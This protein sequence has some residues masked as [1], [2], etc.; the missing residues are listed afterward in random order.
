MSKMARNIGSI[1]FGPQ[2]SGTLP[3]TGKR[4][5]FDTGSVRDDRTGKGRYDLL[6]PVAMKRDAIL[7]EKGAIKYNDRNWEKGQPI[8]SYLDSAKRHMEC[9]TLD[10]LM[11]RESEEDH[12]AAVRWN[13]A[14][15]MHMEFMIENGLLP[16]DLDDRP[17]PQTKIPGRKYNN[18]SKIE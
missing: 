9:Y 12:L 5:E 7:M 8:M 16:I 6:S 3:D 15:M 13:I 11:G 10:L 17:K 18:E 4:R 1:V 2:K 14:A